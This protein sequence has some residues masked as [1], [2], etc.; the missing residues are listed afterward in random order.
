MSKK[1]YSFSEKF[2]YSFDNFMS[3]GGGS[4]FLAL[5]FLF[6]GAI[7]VVAL[8]R[9][10]ANLIAP[11]EDM[12]N[13]FDQWWLSFLQI[14]D[15]GAIGED[16]DSNFLNKIVGII[17]LFLG[18]VLFSSLVAFITSQ[19]EAK[20][21]ELRRGKSRVIEKG[22]T[23]IL[24]FGDRVLEIIRELIIANESEKSPAIVVLAEKEKDEMDDFFRERI[25]NSKNTRI[26]TRSGSTSSLQ[27]LRKVGV[28]D[29]KSVIILNDSSVA[30]PDR[31]KK[32]SDARVLK[33]VMAAMSCAGED[34]D[35][36]ILTELHFDS[37]RRLARSMFSNIVSIDERSILAKLI[38]QTSRI[39]GL[40]QV[41]DS[42]VG[43]AGSEFYFYKPK[44]GLKGI[45]YEEAMF[46]FE[47][48]C[49]LGIKKA[50]GAII[51]NPAAET[52]F[53]DN[54]EIILIAE[55][56]STIKYLPEMINVNFPKPPDY[57]LA[58]R[59]IES[60][61]IV[62]WSEKVKIIMDE[63]SDYL[64]NGSNIVVV[65]SD[66]DETVNQDFDEVRKKHPKIKMS[67]LKL[68]I[69]NEEDIAKL[70][71]E[72]FNSI[73][74]LNP[75]GGDAELKDSETIASLLE[76][77]N[78]LKKLDLKN[79]K[80]QLI[81]EVADSDNIELIQNVGVKDFLISN[82][83]VSKIYAQ[84]SEDP[85]VLKIYED[86]FSSEGNE[87]YIKPISLFLSDVSGGVTFGQLCAAA[88]KRKETCFGVRIKSLEE[89]STDNYGI[90]INP[91]K[92]KIFNL[93]SEDMLITLA[94]DET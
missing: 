66:I 48:S 55:D 43:F 7:V 15:G 68:D 1:D 58:Q 50:K 54:D 69:H 83:F 4:I 28:K 94:E 14:A 53:E 82:Q 52:V 65:L 19:F 56:D 80:T 8:F 11:Q 89:S 60:Q 9:F 64:L 6:L 74:I 61:L 12:A 10:I 67:L 79:V 32:L 47:T 57:V 45:R 36:P 90:Y 20:L 30:A 44:S 17:A 49:V 42:L 71:P 33:T 91:D 70:K 34:S 5:M 31:E 59:S 23:L 24:G 37:K 41:Y 62:G 75:D 39:S 72:Q 85:E 63:Y 86:L 13:L 84:C 3:R 81:T 73:I 18:M 77:R 51:L 93:S 2:K 16:T 29:A 38:V 22:H 78:Y 35:L 46:R 88:I 87:V 76:F 25:E 26:I 40:A 92:S 21:D 27:A